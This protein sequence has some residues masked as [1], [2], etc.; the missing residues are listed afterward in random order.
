MV[1]SNT[2]EREREM[3]EVLDILRGFNISI[4]ERPMAVVA[5]AGDALG[6]GIEDE[7]SGLANNV[8]YSFDVCLAH[9]YLSDILV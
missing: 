3:S 6:D 2:S 8:R 7:L 1:F 9:G 5:D 4:T